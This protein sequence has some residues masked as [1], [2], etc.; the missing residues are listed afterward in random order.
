MVDSISSHEPRLQ[1]VPAFSALTFTSVLFLTPGALGDAL[2]L[3]V[4]QWWPVPSSGMASGEFPVDKVVHVWL[5]GLLGYLFCKE[6]IKTRRSV[7]KL[8]VLLF[9]YGAGIELLQILIPGR[10]ASIG[11]L[12][13]DNVGIVMGFYLAMRVKEMP[14]KLV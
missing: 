10:G 4:F 3:W 1:L 8:Y 9:L 2:L 12:V 13:A 14:G 7:V 6:W 5:F 11:D